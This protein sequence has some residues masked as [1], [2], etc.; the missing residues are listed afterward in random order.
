MSTSKTASIL[1]DGA[2]IHFSIAGNGFPV[3]LIQGVGVEGRGF[4][5]QVDTLART[6]TCVSID[7]RGIGQS[8][9]VDHN[10]ISVATM[11][12]D[13][14]AIADALGLPRFHLVGHSLGGVIAQR[15]ALDAPKRVASVA[16]QCTFAGGRDLAKPSMR[17]IWLGMRSQFGTNDMR[18]NAFTQLVSPPQLCTPSRIEQTMDDLESAFGRDLA[19]PPKVASTQ[20]AALRAHDERERLNELAPIPCLVQSAAFDPIARPEFGRE[21]ATR[22]GRAQFEEWPNAS[23]ALPIQEPTAINTRLLAHFAAA[24]TTRR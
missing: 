15:V 21:L 10:T 11:A 17:L 13:T 5:P 23:H 24:E 12:K 8:T 18:R 3:L 4:A 20:L 7:N 19:T 16:F 6:H 1:T 22:I 2:T 9:V 14:L